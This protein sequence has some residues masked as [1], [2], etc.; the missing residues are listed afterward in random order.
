MVSIYLKIFNRKHKILVKPICEN[1]LGKQ[2]LFVGIVNY[3]QF[4]RQKIDPSPPLITP[5]PS[6]FP[7]RPLPLITP[8]FPNL[9]IRLLS[10]ITPPL[11]NLP[12]RPLPL[13]PLI[14]PPRPNLLPRTIPL[15][16]ELKSVISFFI[17]LSSRYFL[18]GRCPI[19]FGNLGS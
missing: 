1:L 3:W 9:L 14:T 16:S 19:H 17:L 18:V 10:L 8:Y 2:F 6:N 12:R 15:K 4:F 7:P 5:S 13:L 11:P